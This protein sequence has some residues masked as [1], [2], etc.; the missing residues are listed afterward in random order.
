[1]LNVTFPITCPECSKELLSHLPAE[2]INL[3]LLTD[4]TLTL[5]SACHDREWRASAHE[6]EQIRQYLWAAQLV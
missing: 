3:V 4:G 6:I 1:M 2:K 5:R